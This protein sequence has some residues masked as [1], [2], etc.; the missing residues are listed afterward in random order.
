[1]TGT[2]GFRQVEEAAARLSGRI[3]TTGVLERDS[4]NRWLGCRVHF[5]CENQQ[6]TGSF[7]F[8]GA[9][10]AV[11]QLPEE[12]GAAGVATHSS[13]NHGAA[14]A[15]AATSA[16]MPARIVVP[17]GASPVKRAAIERYG[18]TVVS[19]GDTLADREA[20]L[21]AVC[22]ET[23]ALFVPPYDHPHIVAGQGTAALELLTAVPDLDEIW[24]PV[25]GGGLAGGTL[26][27]ASGWGR[28]VRVV[29][30]EP[31]LA[32]DAFWS[33][34]KGEIQA[35]RPPVTVADGLRTALGRLPFELFRR[36]GLTIATVSET[37]IESAVRLVWERLKLVVEP[38]GA[39]GLAGLAAAIQ[40]EPDRYAG[41][42]VGVILSGGNVA[43]PG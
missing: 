43:P 20:A 12:A 21:A 26:L 37:A 42:N 14:L 32:D 17:E 39:V 34:A 15:L 8:R 28:S 2:I 36:H 38:S 31:E 35:Q 19:C 24:V 25:G 30:V 5:K 41:L 6:R 16:G 27:A 7:K 22:R 29:G 13:G 23:G 3:L 4:F 18:G 10:N 9:C 33:L 1:M 40:T 11:A